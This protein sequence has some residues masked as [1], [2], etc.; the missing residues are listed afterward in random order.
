MLQGHSRQGWARPSAGITP[1]AASC[2]PKVLCL[3][4]GTP[5]EPR[6]AAQGLQISSRSSAAAPDKPRLGQAPAALSFPQQ[7]DA[8][9]PSAESTSPSENSPLP[10]SC[11]TSLPSSSASSLSIL[12]ARRAAENQQGGRGFPV[13][14]GNC[15]PW[16]CRGMSGQQQLGTHLQA[17]SSQ[18]GVGCVWRSPPAFPLSWAGPAQPLQIKVQ[19]G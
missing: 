4:M 19:R 11:S 16:S 12:G 3:P 15:R 7:Q 18:A 9:L 1:R 10:H 5:R 17:D 6:M 8:L 13:E 2:G 14:S